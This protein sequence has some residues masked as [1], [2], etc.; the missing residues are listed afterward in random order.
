[1]GELEKATSD[2]YCNQY[3]M[4]YDWK[5]ITQQLK[6]LNIKSTK[7]FKTAENSKDDKTL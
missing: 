2:S 4:L 6:R 5:C 3:K 1:M 7:S